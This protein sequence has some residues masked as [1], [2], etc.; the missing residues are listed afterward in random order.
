MKY[1][2]TLENKR[3]KISI[4]ANKNTRQHTSKLQLFVIL[5]NWFFGLA[6][7]S[8]YVHCSYKENVST[9]ECNTLLYC[10]YGR[11]QLFDKIHKIQ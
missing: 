3:S 10:F 8:V 1:R 5:L 9:G 11:E 6:I 4:T 7:L 2:E